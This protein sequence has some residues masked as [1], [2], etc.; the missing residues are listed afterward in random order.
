[1]D[2]DAKK[3][4]HKERQCLELL[5]AHLDSDAPCIY[6]FAI[7]DETGLTVK[8]VRRALRSLKKKGLTTLEQT[9]GDEGV[10]GSGYCATRVGRDFFGQAP[11]KE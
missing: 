11:P 1:M 3:I 2:E 8:E 5:V 9:Y 4:N 10:S 6:M 7:A